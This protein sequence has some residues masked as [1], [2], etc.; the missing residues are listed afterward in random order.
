M[1]KLTAKIATFLGGLYF[2]LEFLLPKEIQINE[3]SFKFGAYYQEITKGIVLLSSLAIGL[4]VLN[5]L[6]IHGQ[7]IL[8]SKKQIFPSQVLLASFFFTLIVQ[9]GSWISDE[10]IKNSWSEIQ[11]VSDY[12][13]LN[14]DGKTSSDKKEKVVANLKIILSNSKIPSGVTKEEYLGFIKLLLDDLEKNTE[15]IN[16]NWPSSLVLKITEFKKAALIRAAS[17]KEVSFWSRADYIIFYGFFLPL[18]S[19]MF[20]ILGF[21]ITYAAYRS[22][23]VRSV[24]A[25]VMMIAALLVILGQIPQGVIY[26]S[27]SLPSLRLWIIEYI[28]TPAFRAIYFCS[29]LAGLSLAVRMWFSM[30]KNPFL[31]K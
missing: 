14:E 24:E 21:Y 12:L 31:E 10:R 6:M 26:I 27:E 20:S 4:G 9:F 29:A 5:L 15:T 8:R 25:S 19:S 16:Q 17:E 11:A 7:K 3:G 23:R 22:F 18:G 30:D 1:V 13:S 28:S 2:F